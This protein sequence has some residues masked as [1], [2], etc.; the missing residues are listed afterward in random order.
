MGTLIH[1]VWATLP[2]FHKL[3]FVGDDIIPI[4]MTWNNP[5]LAADIKI[6]SK[7]YEVE[8]EYVFEVGEPLLLT[9]TISNI[10]GESLTS[11]HVPAPAHVT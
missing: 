6:N 8:Q 4:P 3:N 5:N 9:V 11:L 7:P 2:L 1:L 10:S